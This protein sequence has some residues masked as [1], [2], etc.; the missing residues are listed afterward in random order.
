MIVAVAVAN[1]DG[2]PHWFRGWYLECFDF[3]A[4]GGVGE[5]GFTPD[6]DKAMQWAGMA[7]FHAFYTRSPAC[8]PSR[9]DGRP[10][11]PLTATTWELIT[12]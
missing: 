7:E 10:N 3:E 12:I 9:S 2:S 4:H 8:R 1:G 6:L 11:R 5:G